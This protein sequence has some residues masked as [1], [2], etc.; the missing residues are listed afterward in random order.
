M[1]FYIRITYL[2][3]WG[4]G[5]STDEVVTNKNNISCQLSS[6]DNFLLLLLFKKPWIGIG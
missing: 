1:F 6:Q 5:Q 2:L 3:S 4:L